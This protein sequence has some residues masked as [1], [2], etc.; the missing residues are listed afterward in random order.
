[1][2]LTLHMGMWLRGRPI[3][4]RCFGMKI[5]IATW[6]GQPIATPETYS[7]CMAINGIKASTVTGGII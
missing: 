5:T 3:M 6:R 7:S 4:A 2:C 1:M